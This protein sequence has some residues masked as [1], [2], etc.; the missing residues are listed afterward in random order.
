[1]TMGPEPMTRMRLMEVSLG[2]EGGALRAG[3]RRSRRG[4]GKTFL[5]PDSSF[6]IRPKR[7]APGR[8][9][10]QES[11]ITEPEALLPVLGA[12]GQRDA[13]GKSAAS[14]IVNPGCKAAVAGKGAKGRFSVLLMRH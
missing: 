8:I 9:R 7:C 14:C 4:D 10:N 1:M 5:M 3:D 12:A 11:K 2:M 6:L 13:G